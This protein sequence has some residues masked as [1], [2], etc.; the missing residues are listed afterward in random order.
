MGLHELEDH[1][2]LSLGL[3]SDG[4][5]A[6]TTALVASFQPVNLLALGLASAGH[7]FQADISLV[8]GEEVVMATMVPLLGPGS[9]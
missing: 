5:H 6:A 2:V 7:G 4:V 3:H 8:P 9:A 1:V